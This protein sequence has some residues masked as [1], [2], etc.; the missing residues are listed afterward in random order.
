MLFRSNRFLAASVRLQPIENPYGIKAGFKR[1]Y[2]D[3]VD[4]RV[5][6]TMQV[7]LQGRSVYLRVALA[8]E[9]VGGKLGVRVVDAA[10]GQLPI[11]GP[12]ANYLLPLWNPCFDSL[13]NVLAVFKNA[14]SAEVT[15]KRV[16]VRWPDASSR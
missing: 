16:V 7:E 11:P 3:L 6:F 4:G 12:L 14:K 13:E 5:D 1:C 15:S 2:L 9:T 8:P 10:L